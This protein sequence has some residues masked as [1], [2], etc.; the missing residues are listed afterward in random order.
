MSWTNPQVSDFQSYFYRDFPFGESD[1]NTSV[2]ALDVTNAFQMTNFNINQALFPCQSD[3]TIGYLLLSAHY[4]V[5]NLRNSSQGLKGK[6][7][8]LEQSKGVGSINSSYGIP[9]RI[10]DNPYWTQLMTTNYGAQYLNLIL[11]QLA[12]AVYVA[13]G[14]S[15]P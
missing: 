14:R 2:L 11:P 13:Y 4:L 8:W 10:L 6:F 15:L 1:P 9:Q 12:G 3:Y 5:T 7:T